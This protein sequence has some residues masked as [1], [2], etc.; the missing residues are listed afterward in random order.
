MLAE[1]VVCPPIFSFRTVVCLRQNDGLMD[2]WVN[3]FTDTNDEQISSNKGRA[4]TSGW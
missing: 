4:L 1:T 2:Y 3:A